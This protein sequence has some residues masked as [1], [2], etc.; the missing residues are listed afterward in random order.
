MSP[1]NEIF[2][3]TPKNKHPIALFNTDKLCYSR[4][5]QIPTNYVTREYNNFLSQTPKP[6]LNL[7]IG[8]IFLSLLT[9]LKN[10]PGVVFR[11][12]VSAENI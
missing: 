9:K 3:F 10:R 2:P 11:K 1:K 5:Q 12:V 8:K 6:I 7:Y 4:I